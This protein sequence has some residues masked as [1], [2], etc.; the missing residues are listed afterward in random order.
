[1]PRQFIINLVIPGVIIVIAIPLILGKVP[2]NR[3]YGFRTRYTLSSDEVW[4]RANKISSIA[5]LIAGLFWLAAAIV[6]PATMASSQSPLLLVRLLGPVSIVI[7]LAVS[8]W[9][10]YKK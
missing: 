9:L 6:L 8:F 4:Y 5:M 10:I 1:M 3:F 7:A 2:R